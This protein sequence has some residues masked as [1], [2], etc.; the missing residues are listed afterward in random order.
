[1]LLTTLNATDIA[2]GMV[3]K[4]GLSEKM[5]PLSYSEE[6][7]EVFLGHSVTQT[8]TVSDETAHTIDG[9]VRR[10]IDNNY[11]R[12]KNI[13][14]ENLDKLHVMADALVKY[15]TIDTDQ[16]DDIMAGKQP[17][18]PDG[19]EDDNE[20]GGSNEGSSVSSDVEDDTGPIGGPAS[21]H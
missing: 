16:I 15:E 14:T 21:L 11:E 2:R 20:S 17:R 9:E 13:L 19:W 8:K 4:W 5:G 10:I 12:A 18:S 7:G 1:V 3:T 6:D